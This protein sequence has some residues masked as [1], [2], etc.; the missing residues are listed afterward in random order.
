MSVCCC[1]P[2]ILYKHLKGGDKLTLNLIGPQNNNATTASPSTPSTPKH[3][4]LLQPEPVTPTNQKPS[5]TTLNGVSVTHY[6]EQR[7]AMEK[8][9]IP[10]VNVFSTEIKTPKLDNSAH[11]N[12]LI[13]LDDS[14]V[15]TKNNNPFLNMSPQLTPTTTVSPHN[16]F[17]VT[18]TTLF[19]GSSPI[20]P[21]NASPAIISTT[22]LVPNQNPFRDPT[23]HEVTN[24]NGRPLIDVTDAPPVMNNNGET[25][26]QNSSR[27]AEA[28][29]K[30]VSNAQRGY[31]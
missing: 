11:S 2:F 6:S 1:V 20:S 10:S 24:G 18:P 23:E 12:N 7:G 9:S 21:V 30:K 3:Y 22:T 25:K 19:S 31:G 17:K 15:P 5:N 4:S 28:V 26:V 8:I 14:P 27:I 29:E 13:Q 16:P